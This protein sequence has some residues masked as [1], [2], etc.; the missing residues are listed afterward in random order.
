MAYER[1]AM[2]SQDKNTQLQL[3]HKA[4]DI[5][6]KGVDLNPGNSYYWGNLGRIYTDLGKSEDPKY[7]DDAEKYYIIAVEKAPVTGLFASNLIE[8]YLSIGRID[9]ALPLM[10]KLESCDKALAA[11]SYFLLGN[12]YFGQKLY[13]DAEKAYRKSLDLNPGFGQTYY[14]LGVVCAA[15]GDRACAKFCMEKYL[16]LMPGSEKETDARKILR[17]VTR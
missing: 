13:L 9:K 7:F 6:K 11:S 1:L 14:N 16:E 2:S 15:R 17:D 12:I 8:L 3:L 10:E 5:Y 4:A